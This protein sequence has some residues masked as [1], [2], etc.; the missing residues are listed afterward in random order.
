MTP[1]GEGTVESNDLLRQE[2]RCKVYTKEDTYDIKT[3]KLCDLSCKV[4]QSV[5]DAD[6]ELDDNLKSIID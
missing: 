6:V 5:S 1:D 4:K 3:Y 2:C